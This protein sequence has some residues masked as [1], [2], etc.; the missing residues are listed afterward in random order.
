LEPSLCKGPSDDRLYNCNHV[1]IEQK[2]D[3]KIYF[4]CQNCGLICKVAKGEQYPKECAEHRKKQLGQSKPKIC[5]LVT[6]D[7]FKS[8]RE[9]GCSEC[10]N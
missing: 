1:W 6:A 2:I 9:Y 7:S 5:K 10:E 8:P 4:R 3:G